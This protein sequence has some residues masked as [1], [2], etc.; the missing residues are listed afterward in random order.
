MDYNVR[1]MKHALTRRLFLK[2]A[3]LAAGAVAS[4]TVMSRGAPAAAP[5]SGIL[6]V[7]DGYRGIWYFNQPTK[8]EYKFKY[9]GGM[10]TYP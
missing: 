7:D 3:A 9:S 8:D 6:G 4:T 5:G 2:H 1:A 10:A